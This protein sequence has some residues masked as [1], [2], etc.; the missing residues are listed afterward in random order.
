M[1]PC[2]P[3]QNITGP[4]IG[5]APAAAP[6]PS[7]SN[8]VVPN[9]NASSTSPTA[10]STNHQSPYDLRKK[11]PPS[12]HELWNGPC[13]CPIHLYFY[14]PFQVFIANYRM[15]GII[16][17]VFLYT[18]CTVVNTSTST[19]SGIPAPT[20]SCSSTSSSSSSTSSSC[21]GSGASGELSSLS[22]PALT[23]TSVS[24]PQHFLFS[25]QLFAA[26]RILFNRHGFFSSL[27]AHT[28]TER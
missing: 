6:N 19:S 10:T 1:D 11:S 16:F 23:S 13:E 24:G 18:V 8:P 7:T 4:N 20:G 9:I 15:N 17:I 12:N 22:F 14:W 21:S 26:K 2:E 27:H 25:S 28:T 3:C 5:S